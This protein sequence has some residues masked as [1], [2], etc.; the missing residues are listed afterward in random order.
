MTAHCGPRILLGQ[1]QGIKFSRSACRRTC[2]SSLFG[3]QVSS[4]AN[5]YRVKQSHMIESVGANVVPYN[6]SIS[7]HSAH[8]CGCMH[9]LNGVQGFNFAKSQHEQATNQAMC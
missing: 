4:S 2:G 3:C 9:V 5:Y 6:G 8:A 1:R 7:M